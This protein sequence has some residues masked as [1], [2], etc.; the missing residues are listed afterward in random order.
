MSVRECVRACV[1]VGGGTGWRRRERG[2]QRKKMGKSGPHGRLPHGRA[3]RPLFLKA[4]DN[5]PGV[6][7]ED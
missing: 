4:K 6:M 1:C 5:S 2:K 7:N 3:A